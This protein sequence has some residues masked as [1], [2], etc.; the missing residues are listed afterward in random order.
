MLNQQSKLLQMHPFT[1][2][3]LM[4]RMFIIMSY[5]DDSD[6]KCN[7][8]EFKLEIKFLSMEV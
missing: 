3:I 7:V 2:L 6:N 5:D 8:L 4:F 1:M